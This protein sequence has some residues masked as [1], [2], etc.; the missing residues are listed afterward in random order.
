MVVNWFTSVQCS[1]YVGFFFVFLTHEESPSID[2]IKSFFVFLF[3]GANNNKGS[4]TI[5]NT[6]IER[7]QQLRAKVTKHELKCSSRFSSRQQ[8]KSSVSR[9]LNC[10][11]VVIFGQ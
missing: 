6:R 8:W 7:E 3:L 2:P 10:W 11:I 4:A 1:I 5:S 9:R